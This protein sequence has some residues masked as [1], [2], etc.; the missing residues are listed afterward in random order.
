MKLI[1]MVDDKCQ[2]LKHSQQWVETIDPSIL[3]LQ[4]MMQTSTSSS[5]DILKTLA[6]HFSKSIRNK[7][8]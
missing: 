6:A 1:T 5:A 4:A 8:K 3:A 7:T 2:V